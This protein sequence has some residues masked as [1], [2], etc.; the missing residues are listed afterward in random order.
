MFINQPRGP[1]RRHVLGGG[2]A[3]LGAT[4]IL[5]SI[6]LAIPDT[7]LIRAI[8]FDGDTVVAVTDQE[9]LRISTAGKVER[10]PHALS[11]TALSNHP[12]RSGTFL[13]ALKDGGLRRSLDGGRTWSNVGFGLPANQITALTIAALD[14]N[15]IYAALAEDGIWRSKDTGDTWEFVMDRPYPDGS[16]HD[17]L[18]LVSV[19]NPSG[20]GGIWLY[21][22]TQVGL[23]RVP[24]CFCR[25]QDVTAGDAMDALAAGETLPPPKPLPAGE[26][27]VALA[28]APDAPKRIYAGLMSGLWVSTDAGVN[29]SLVSSG[30]ISALAVNP[31]DPLH[32][33]AVRDGGLSISRDGGTTWTS[34]TNFKEI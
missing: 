34:T 20:M 7:T 24:D 18:S 13:A 21:A 5:P 9:L 15:L 27:I 19:G 22:G 25:W 12:A 29:W 1:S 8:S 4:L 11:V 33:A 16:E 30:A 26:A 3:A 31:S 6:T 32:L 14:A 23:T 10:V 17:V 2:L 28:L